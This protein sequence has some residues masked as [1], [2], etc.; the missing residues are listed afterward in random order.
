MKKYFVFLITLLFFMAA[1]HSKEEAPQPVSDL[2]AATQEGKYTIGCYINGKPW[3]PQPY[4]TWGASP[5]LEAVYKSP[6]NN[7]TTIQ[8]QIPS[9][10][11]F[12]TLVA[13]DV[14]LGHNTMMQR[15]KACYTDYQ[16]GCFNGRDYLLDTTYIRNLNITKIDTVKQ[17]I[18]GTFEFRAI[19]PVCKDTLYFTQGRFDTHY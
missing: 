14:K 3:V 4:I 19:S 10:G 11:Q 2:P 18:A 9:L 7:F 8:A 16:N 15:S 1:C 5:F 6:W 13:E 12:L 17:I